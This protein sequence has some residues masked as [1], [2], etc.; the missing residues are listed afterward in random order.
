MKQLWN[1]KYIVK[2]GI[3]FPQDPLTFKN[4]ETEEYLDPTTKKVMEAATEDYTDMNM[5]YVAVEEQYA[6]VSTAVQV[7]LEPERMSQQS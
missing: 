6:E 7:T 3:Y 1:A 4:P 2:N 5:G